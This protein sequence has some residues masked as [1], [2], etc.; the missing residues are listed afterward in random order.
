[1]IGTLILIAQMPVEPRRR[2]RLRGYCRVNG[3]KGEVVTVEL[4][5]SL[6][7][8]EFCGDNL[9]QLGNS[10]D[11][12]TRHCAGFTRV[13]VREL[14]ALGARGIGHFLFPSGDLLKTDLFRVSTLHPVLF[15]W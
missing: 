2:R 3:G 7:G 9:T 15:L 13:T 5:A 10:R 12:I 6:K 1:M 11:L 14:R 4:E 8:K